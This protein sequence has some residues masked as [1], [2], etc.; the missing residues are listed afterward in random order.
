[1]EKSHTEEICGSP[2][3]LHTDSQWP[4][5]LYLSLPFSAGRNCDSLLAK[6][7]R[8]KGWNVTLWLAYVIWDS[9]ST[10]WVRDSPTGFEEWGVILWTAWIELYAIATC[11][12]EPRTAPMIAQSYNLKDLNSA[13][14]HMSLEGNPELQQ[15]YTQ[16][17][18]HLNCSFVRRWV[19]YSVSHAQISPPHIKNACSFRLLWLG[20]LVTQQ[21]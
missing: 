4:M 2:P 14:K 19:G 17:G 20:S 3:P 11:S 13:K 5:A 21:S 7:I 15:K 16:P 10:V 6:R 8:Q 12:R 18:W 9:V 1:M